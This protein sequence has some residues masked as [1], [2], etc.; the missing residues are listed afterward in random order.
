M[1]A[2]IIQQRNQT[3][4]MLSLYLVSC[5]MLEVLP[6]YFIKRAPTIIIINVIF[7]IQTSIGICGFICSNIYLILG[8]LSSMSATIF[9][10]LLYFVFAAFVKSDWVLLMIHGIPMIFDLFTLCSTAKTTLE[11]WKWRQGL[12]AKVTAKQFG[13]GPEAAVVETKVFSS[14][15]LGAKPTAYENCSTS[16]SSS[17]ATISETKVGFFTNASIKTGV[18][19]ETMRMEAASQFDISKLR[20]NA[21]ESRGSSEVSTAENSEQCDLE[22]GETDA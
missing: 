3:I 22:K 11:Y 5:C 21:S 10:F 17:E 8:F 16:N 9:V 6:L 15:E 12:A 13:F 14:S 1:T 20:P 7:G 19:V 18:S 2:E 4:L